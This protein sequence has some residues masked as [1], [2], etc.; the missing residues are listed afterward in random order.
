[1]RNAM[2]TS[3][4][5]AGSAMHDIGHYIDGQLIPRPLLRSRHRN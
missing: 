4:S 2:T 3:N 5:N 1:M